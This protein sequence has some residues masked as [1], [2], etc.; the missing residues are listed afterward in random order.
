MLAK[1]YIYQV[2]GCLMGVTQREQ[3]LLLSYSSIPAKFS[4]FMN[5]IYLCVNYHKLQI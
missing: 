2:V 1:H 4:V 3:M 5:A